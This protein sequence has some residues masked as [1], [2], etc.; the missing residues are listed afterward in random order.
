MGD[1]ESQQIDP[2]GRADHRR[3]A[4]T[5]RRDR[6]ERRGPDGYGCPGEGR[7][8]PGGSD[9]DGQRDVSAHGSG[10]GGPRQGVLHRGRGAPRR[11]ALRRGA[12]ARCLGLRTGLVD[13]QGASA[14]PGVGVCG[15]ERFGDV[16][17]QLRVQPAPAPAERVV[18]GAPRRASSPGVH[19]ASP[20]EVPDAHGDLGEGR[21]PR[22]DPG[23]GEIGDDGVD[24]VHAA[25]AV[26]VV[27]LAVRC[28]ASAFFVLAE[29]CPVCG[30]SR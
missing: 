24:G 13:D 12:V 17:D 3:G 26:P 9:R 1:G 28:H 5:A 14:P 7:G 6:A 19:P 11:S 29:R 23:L 21:H 8:A 15:A 18:D 30:V 4:R 10:R 25:P 27:L 16:A 22:G 20:P 2:D